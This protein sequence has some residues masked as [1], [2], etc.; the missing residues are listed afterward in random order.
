[1]RTPNDLIPSSLRKGREKGEK[2][3]EIKTRLRAG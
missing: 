1:M 3:E 2:E